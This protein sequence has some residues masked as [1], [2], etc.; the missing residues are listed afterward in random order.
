MSKPS[1]DIVG[2]RV[3]LTVPELLR[4]EFETLLE[5]H[6]A[7]VSLALLDEDGDIEVAPE[8]L[9]R[10]SVYC[11]DAAEGAALKA[12]LAEAANRDVISWNAL[13]GPFVTATLSCF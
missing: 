8:H 6:A 9:W 7:A 4:A 11:A 2:W 1:E 13:S 3:D 10:L 12:L 5:A